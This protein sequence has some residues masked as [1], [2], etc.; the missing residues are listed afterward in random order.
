[1]A[2]LDCQDIGFYL[3]RLA[4]GLS[5]PVG[6][7]GILWQG[8]DI[9]R[10]GIALA[11]MAARRISTP[12]PSHSWRFTTCDPAVLSELRDLYGVLDDSTIHPSSKLALTRKY[13]VTS[14]AC[15]ATTLPPL[16]DIMQTSRLDWLGAVGCGNA[17]GQRLGRYGATVTEDGCQFP[18]D[19]AEEKF[20]SVY[21]L[22]FD[23]QSSEVQMRS[24]IATGSGA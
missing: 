15:M 7:I 22:D 10:D 18:N 21:A 13:R 16:A 5:S 12:V 9:P 19:D 23:E 4:P 3:A 8:R 24:V 14:V 11:A 2:T 6:A 20:N 17:W 1:M